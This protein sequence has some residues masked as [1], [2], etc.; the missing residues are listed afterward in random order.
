MGIA[1]FV[2]LIGLALSALVLGSAVIGIRRSA[3]LPSKIRSACCAGCKYPIDEEQPISVCPECGRDLRIAGVL[4]PELLVRMRGS[5]SIIT[6]GVLLLTLLVVIPLVVTSIFI[7]DPMDDSNRGVLIAMR[8]GAG[9]VGFAGV[10]ALVWLHGRRKRLLNGSSKRDAGPP[11]TPSADA[12]TTP[13][14]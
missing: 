6:A 7:Y 14:E 8:S 11:E 3:F 12:S 4:T 5:R 9:V 2:L 13:G 10:W 1:A